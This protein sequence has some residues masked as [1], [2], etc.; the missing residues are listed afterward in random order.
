MTLAEAKTPGLSKENDILDVTLRRIPNTAQEK[1]KNELENADRP[2]RRQT[3][4][5][6][7]NALI[8]TI[9]HFLSIND[10]RMNAMISMNTMMKKSKKRKV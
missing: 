7:N 1:K 9:M 2:T 4:Q 5:K 3:I 6:Q 10:T 8:I